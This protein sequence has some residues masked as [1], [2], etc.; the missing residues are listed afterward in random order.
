MKTFK[1]IMNVIG[2][3]CASIL[4]IFLV[5]ALTVTPI[6]NAASSFFQGENIYKII[7]S[8]DYSAI[9]SSE[10]EETVEVELVNDLM[11]SEMMEEVV[12]LCVE[13][14]FEAIE[15]NDINRTVSPDD[16]EDIFEDHKDEIREL[17]DEYIGD[18]IPL[19][20]E[21][22]DEMTDALI[23]QYSI[24]MAESLPTVYDLGLDDDTL[25][26]IMNLKNGTYLKIVI[27]IVAVLSLI[28]MLCQVMRFKGFMWIGVDYL[29]SAIL[30]F[31]FSA[32]IKTI[33]FSAV[34]GL[35]VTTS[36]VFSTIVEIISLDMIKSAIVITVL[37][38]VFIAVF[39]VGRKVLKK[40]KN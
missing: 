31:I 22:L 14:I 38:V 17:V 1:I 33:D 13:N 19:T 10:M 34:I 2:I 37:G 3:I 35:D 4:S 39:V 36:P 23:Q 32:V 26:I 7:S 29:L 30:A 21:V 18:N 6:I 25:N 9:I 27:S 11:Q 8:V 40:K 12:D 5:L 16:I 28:V 15:E 20:E 24:E